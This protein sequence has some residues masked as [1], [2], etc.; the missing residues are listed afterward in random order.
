MNLA[1]RESFA[2][3]KRPRR[4]FRQKTRDLG[5]PTFDVTK[6]NAVSAELEDAEIL[7]KISGPS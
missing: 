2:T 4:P 5:R 1:L 6:A 3:E 7:R